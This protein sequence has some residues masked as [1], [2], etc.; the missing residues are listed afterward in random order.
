MQSVVSVHP[1]VFH[2]VFVNQLTFDLEFCT[3]TG[4]DYSLASKVIG[5]GERS[6]M[7]KMYELTIRTVASYEY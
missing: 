2:S 5:Q 6:T 3:H 7:H 4:H 1:S